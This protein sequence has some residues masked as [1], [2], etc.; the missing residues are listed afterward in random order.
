MVIPDSK[1]QMLVVAWF[2]NKSISDAVI[3][4]KRA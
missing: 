3:P 1:P 4:A 2:E